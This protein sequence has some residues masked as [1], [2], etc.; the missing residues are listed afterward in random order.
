[1]LCLFFGVMARSPV[2][3]RLARWM[4]SGGPGRSSRK[5]A[6]RGAA[7]YAMRVP[8]GET[9]GAMSAERARM[10]RFTWP[11]ARLPAKMSSE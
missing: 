9:V 8:S 3:S 1:M 4:R 5:T 11:V 2:P 6:G 7:K 10:T